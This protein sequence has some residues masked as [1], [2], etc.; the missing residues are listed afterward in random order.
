MLTHCDWFFG[1]VDLDHVGGD[2][3]MLEDAAAAA[4]FHFGA[5]SFTG[6]MGGVDAH[7]L[8]LHNLQKLEESGKMQH[9]QQMSPG[10]NCVKIGLPDSQ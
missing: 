10:T 6:A 2:V 1:G 4:A 7:G 5:G 8:L 3:I 9:M